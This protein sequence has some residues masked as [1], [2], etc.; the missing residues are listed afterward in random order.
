[1]LSG[2]R[3]LKLQRCCGDALPC[4][5]RLHVVPELF[6][7]LQVKV[8]ENPR[9]FR[10]KKWLQTAHPGK[11]SERKI[12]PPII[13]CKNEELNHY[14][15]LTYGKFDVI[16]LASKGWLHRKSKGDYFVIHEHSQIP[17]RSEQPA[18]FLDL[19][20]SEEVV[21]I[22]RRSGI[23]E[24]T[25]IQ[26]AGIPA[27]SSGRN[28]LLAAETGCGKTLAYLLPL[29]QQLAAA[30][31]GDSAPGDPFNSPLALVVTPSRELAA[32][33]GELANNFS[34]SLLFASKYLVGGR[35][36]RKMMNPSFEKV[37][38]L[39]ASLG[40]LSKLTSAGVYNMKRVRHIVLDEADTLLD[41][42]FNEKLRHFLRRFPLQVTDGVN[43]RRTQLTLPESLERVTTG[44]L[45]RIMPHVPQR[46]VRLGLSQRPAELLRLA[47]ADFENKV[48]V[49]VFS[50][51]SAT[52]DWVS[53]F[54]NENGVD[55]VNLNKDMPLA[56][57]KG[58]FE[59][60]QRGEAN[61]ISCT[62]IGS[63]GLDTVRVKHVINYEFPLYMAD[64]IHRCGRTG[65]VGSLEGCHVTNFVSG[66]L[67][68][69]LVQ[70]IELAARTTDA[71]PNVNAN[72]S[73]VI[74]FRALK[75]VRQRGEMTE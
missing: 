40:A 74:G 31:A 49:I 11:M 60:F 57:R 36:K 18:S 3:L 45:H 16:P 58:V 68:V 48:P 21:G 61:V 47:R 42:S 9:R 7:K 17:A 15:S 72:I 50:N 71:L 5:A 73:R 66:K 43:E 39:V 30:A 41:D 44:R 54:L 13:K 55:C 70:A 38:L 26:E 63:R 8:K 51:K 37:D 23:T 34:R 46:F 24:P 10:R 29:V 4:V 35:T 6:S 59:K 65:R 12:G 25:Q 69:K 22:L 14:K 32:Q 28:V 67:D 33:I 53:M 56:L 64:Y 1:M 27:V 2:V 20:L 62:D 75:A 52:S 19:G